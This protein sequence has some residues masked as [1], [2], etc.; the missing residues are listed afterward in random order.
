[1]DIPDLIN[2]GFE[3]FSS[4][5]LLASCQRVKKE[6]TATGVSLITICFFTSWGLWNMYYYPSLG[7]SLSFYCGIL[8]VLA[9]LYWIY[10][11]VKYRNVH[12]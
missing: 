6:K 8:V 2:A 12:D 11:I 1:M 9:N 3:F 10:L 7:Q 5:A 4:L